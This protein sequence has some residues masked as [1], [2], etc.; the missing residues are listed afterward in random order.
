MSSSLTGDDLL[1]LEEIKRLKYAYL[2]CLDQ[3]RWDELASLF[4]PDATAAYGGGTHTY[5]GRD[6]ILDF[7]RSALGSEQHLTVH[8]VHQPEI[9]LTGPDGATGVWAFDDVVIMED[10]QLTIRGAGFYTDGYVRTDAGWRITTTGYKRT[11]EEIQPRGPVEGLR[12]TAT[13]W[14]T[15]GRSSLG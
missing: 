3:K 13:W 8:R 10:H 7:L 15:D 6:A 4:T 1:T 12:L 9:E 11:Y 14:G 5:D 2:R